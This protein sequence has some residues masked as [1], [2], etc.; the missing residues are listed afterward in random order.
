MTRTALAPALVAV[1]LA[2]TAAAMTPFDRSILLRTPDIA[3]LPAGFSHG[4]EGRFG[5]VAI[6]DGATGRTRVEP[7]ASALLQMNWVVDTDAGWRVAFTFG[8]EAGN[9]REYR[10]PAR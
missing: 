4:F 6:R 9:L 3:S 1:L 2:G 8:I 7:V 5:A 10:H